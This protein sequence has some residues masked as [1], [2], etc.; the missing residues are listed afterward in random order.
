[1]AAAFVLQLMVL[2]I[3]VQPVLLASWLLWTC[4]HG[5]HGSCK[6]MGL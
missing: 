3:F 6:H 2:C 4:L 1:M 5:L